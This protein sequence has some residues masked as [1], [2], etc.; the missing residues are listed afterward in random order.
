MILDKPLSHSVAQFLH[1]SSEG[2]DLDTFKAIS[3]FLHLCFHDSK[4]FLIE[5]GELQG[6]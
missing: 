6:P 3:S 2:V 4:D 1:L 5:A